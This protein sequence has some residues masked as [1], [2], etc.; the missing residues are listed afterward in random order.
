MLQ[1]YMNWRIPNPAYEEIRNAR[2]VLPIRATSALTSDLPKPDQEISRKITPH[3]STLTR[4]KR[5]SK[6]GESKALGEFPK[7]DTSS[8]GLAAYCSGCKNGL[9]KERRLKD[10]IARI[11]HYTVTRIK[12]E[13]PKEEIP[14]DIQTNLE[15][16]LGYR[17]WELK[18]KLTDE[19][20]AMYGIT[21]VESFKNDF[22]LDHIQPHSSFDAK[23]I[24]DGEF[25]KCWAITNLRM[26]PA[27][28]NLQKGAK[29][30]YY[31]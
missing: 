17:L 4:S 1:V 22:H 20:Q 21:L 10:P 30:D 3:Q 8:D 29:L 28:E 19:V 13:W 27:R 9:A 14:K 25:Q 12:N 16:Y 23:S 15:H 26:I 7:H 18:R 2:R 24:G 5:C 11:T 6:C 31:A